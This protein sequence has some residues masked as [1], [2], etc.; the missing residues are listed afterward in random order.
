MSA[1]LQVLDGEL[2]LED[3]TGPVDIPPH[4]LNAEAAVISAC[5]INSE[6]D[7]ARPSAVKLVRGFLRPAHFFSEAHRRIFEAIIDLDDAGTPADI[8]TIGNRLKVTE[9]LLQ[10][11]GMAYLVEILNEAPVVS[12][13]RQYALAVYDAWRMREAIATAQRFAAAGY[14]AVDGV[15]DFLD[16]GTKALARY[17]QAEMGREEESNV[18]SLKKLFAKLRDAAKARLEGRDITMGATTGL[19]RL[20]EIMHGLRPSKKVQILAT[21]GV[22]KTALALHMA[23]S[24]ASEGVGV[25]YF[26]SEPSMDRESFLLRAVANIAGVDATRLR[27]LNMSVD[28]YARVQRSFSTLSKLPIKFCDARGQTI[29]YVCSQARRY[30]ETFRTE[31]KAPL[32]IVVDDYLQK[33]A[34]PESMHRFSKRHEV[35]AYG[36]NAT[37]ELAAELQ[38]CVVEPAQEKRPE[39]EGAREKKPDQ[40]CGAESSEI[41]KGADTMIVLRRRGEKHFVGMRAAQKVL[42]VIVK[43]RGGEDDVTVPLHFFG[44]EGRFEQTNEPE[45]GFWQ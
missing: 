15:Q 38:V 19:Q 27:A 14:H 44:A 10:V 39:K 23:L 28:E 18:D 9:R 16:R 1:A 32:G 7:A 31:Q 11:G 30:A 37:A 5:M 36:A 33:F 26:W 8:V 12:H 29:D 3:S 22:G 41:E 6:G 4:D 34:P 24:A 35:V 2:E 42:A 45:E 17:S 20:D 21:P 25:A 43:N 13:V 40:A